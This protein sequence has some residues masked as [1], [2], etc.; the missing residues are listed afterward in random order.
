M[1]KHRVH[2]V[3]LIAL[4]P[5]LACGGGGS[6]GADAKAADAP[7]TI[8]DSP[9]IDAPKVIDAEPLDAQAYDFSCLGSADPTTTTA[10]AVTVSGSVESISLSG[11]SAPDATQLQLFVGSNAEAVATVVAGGSGSN[12][13]FAF[14]AQPTNGSAVDL[15]VVATSVTQGEY[16]TDII[17]PPAPLV[18]DEAGV[19][20]LA[21]TPGTFSELAS[22]G[23]GTSQGSGQGALGLQVVDCAGNPI[24]G[25]TVTVTEGGSAAGTVFDTGSLS[26]MAKGLIFVFSVPP[27]VATVTTTV[28]GHTFRTRMLTSVGDATTTTQIRP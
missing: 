7:V 19:P 23:A 11:A 27:G 8:H 18:A 9:T 1:R 17:F 26:S 2:F 3:S 10:Q 20:V 6:G 28:E 14:P 21:V 25:P 5:L 16:R 24:G 12:G 22:L 15:H 13:D 4:T